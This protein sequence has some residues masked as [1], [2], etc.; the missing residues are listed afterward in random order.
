MARCD[1]TFAPRLLS[2]ARAAAYL[3]ISETTLR[4]LALPRRILGTR[5][6]YD[7][8]E[9]DAFADG[10]EVED[11][12]ADQLQKDQAECDRLFGLTS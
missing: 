7:R 11:S 3:G 2:S 5:R 4:T 8:Y 1:L 6:L 12:A 10:L 9:L